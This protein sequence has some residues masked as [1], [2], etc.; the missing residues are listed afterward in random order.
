[1]IFMTE[2]TVTIVG[3]IL[4]FGAIGAGLSAFNCN[5]LA[6]L[7]L[8]PFDIFFKYICGIGGLYA[9]YIFV[10]NLQMIKEL[11]FLTLFINLI[12]ILTNIGIG[13]RGLGTN[14]LHALHME[15]LQKI[16]QLVAGVVGIYSLCMII[17]M[18]NQ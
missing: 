2:N 17:K 15:Y 18:M 12:L 13:I 16:F 6:A 5:L 1:M 4:S 8:K 7:K 10:N 11:G 9:G 3:F 14:I